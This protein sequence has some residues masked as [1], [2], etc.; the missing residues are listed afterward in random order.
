MRST[1]WI[2]SADGL[3]IARID[4]AESQEELSACTVIVQTNLRANA[5]SSVCKYSL[6][7]QKLQG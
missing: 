1:L 7:A 5:G 6:D 4:S 3:T 2:D